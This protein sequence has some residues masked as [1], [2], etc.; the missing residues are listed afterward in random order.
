VLS[1]AGLPTD[2]NPSGEWY[3]DVG[4]GDALH[5]PLPLRA[6]TYVQG[7]FTLALDETCNGIG[8]WHLT[9]DPAGSFG[10]MSWWSAPAAMDAFA[11]RHRFL[12]TDPDSG[13]VKVLAVQ[14]REA[15]GVH[16]LRGLTLSRI[17]TG[18]SQRDIASRDD[19]LDTLAE[20]F[21]LDVRTR[22]PS[23][24]DL[25]WSKLASGHEAWVAAGRR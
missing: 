23:Q 10:G 12:S 18:A 16:I 15:T 20:V 21:L 19:L 8:D 3:V 6:G 5:E 1:V 17:G 13:F 25:L 14:R 7:P 22:E 2:D 9:H 4:L 11:D 24:L